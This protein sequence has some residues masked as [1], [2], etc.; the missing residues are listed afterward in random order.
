LLGR[1]KNSHS[2]SIALNEHRLL[3]SSL[4]KL[5]FGTLEL[6]LCDLTRHLYVI[7]RVI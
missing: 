4:H 5:A 3:N 6:F 1:D 7:S 2:L